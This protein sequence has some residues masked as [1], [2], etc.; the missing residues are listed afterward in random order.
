MVKKK[1]KKQ[2]YRE[3]RINRVLTS[4]NTRERIS[5]EDQPRRRQTPHP[6]MTGTPIADT[7]SIS[8]GG[9]S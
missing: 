6:H 8:K 2:E 4:T 1:E 5:T 7:R 3:V 9:I